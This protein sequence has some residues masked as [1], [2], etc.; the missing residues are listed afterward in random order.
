MAA[1]AGVEDMVRFSEALPPLGDAARAATEAEALAVDLLRERFKKP[2]HDLRALAALAWPD[3][4][5]TALSEAASGGGGSA[6]RGAA[7]E[8]V[9]QA[10]AG[11]GA[12]GGRVRR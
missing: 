6:E 5:L 12:A 4:D 10:G 8:D 9:S 7:V 11:G 3:A 1:H 2:L